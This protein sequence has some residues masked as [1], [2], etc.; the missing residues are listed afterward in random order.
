MVKALTINII[1]TF[2]VK[3]NC[4]DET[5][6]TLKLLQQLAVHVI[7]IK[8]PHSYH[9][10]IAAAHHQVLGGGVVLST[11]HKGRMRKHLLCC[12]EKPLHIPLPEG[13][14]Q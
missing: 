7:D 6:V 9:R 1:P 14:Q 11:V 3:T 8:P 13:R 4:V 10:V 5:A 12:C 2:R